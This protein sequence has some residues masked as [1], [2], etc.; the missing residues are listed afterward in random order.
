MLGAPSDPRGIPLHFMVSFCI[1]FFHNKGFGHCA[2]AW[3]WG[4]PDPLH[5]CLVSTQGK[6]IPPGTSF[7]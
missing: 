5:L 4:G 1:Q 2:C 3:A 7:V 6:R